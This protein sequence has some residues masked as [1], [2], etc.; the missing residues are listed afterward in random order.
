MERDNVETETGFFFLAAYNTDTRI[1]TLQHTK[2]PDSYEN[3]PSLALL[4]G[5]QF[6]LLLIVAL[7]RVCLSQSMQHI[8]VVV[9]SHYSL[10]QLQLSCFLSDL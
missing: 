1:R 8:Q 9:T 5:I 6:G 7:L 4:A 2:K 10:D 3:T